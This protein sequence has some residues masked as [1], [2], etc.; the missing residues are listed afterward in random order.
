MPP[1]AATAARDAH[2]IAVRRALAASP[3]I[4]MQSPLLVQREAAA[5][6]ATA[7]SCSS[8]C[9]CLAAWPAAASAV[10]T[11]SHSLH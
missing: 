4:M 1:F 9:T 6:T 10:A 3:A 11:A 5:S 2:F 8:C 7:A